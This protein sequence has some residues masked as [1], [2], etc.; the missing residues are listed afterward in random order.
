MAWQLCPEFPPN[1]RLGSVCS[2]CG[3]D[4]RPRRTGGHERALDTGIWIDQE[5]RFVICESCVREA[6]ALI[7]LIDPGAQQAAQE[8]TIRLRDELRDA[9]ITAVAAREAT[10][11]LTAA[12]E[13]EPA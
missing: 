3:S 10:R 5:G 7:D 13:R 8:E 2:V 12:L 11:A 4:L 9:K 1:T 6:A